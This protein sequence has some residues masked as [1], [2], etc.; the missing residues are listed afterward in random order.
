MNKPADHEQIEASKAP[1]LEHLVELRTRLLYSLAGFIVCFFGCYF[2]AEYIYAFL[3][4]PLANAFG[5]ETGRRMIFTA[6]YETF[7]TY[8]RV[9]FFGAM[10]LSFPIVASQIWMFVAPGLYR[11]EKRA[12]LPY[13]VAT[14]LMFIA[15]GAFVFYLVMPVAISFFLSFEAPG[16]E[17]TLPIQLEAK[18]SEYLDLVMTLIFAFGV[19][20]QLPILLTL[21][22][23]VGIIDAATLRMFRRYAIVGVFA[24]AA[25]L[26]PPD[27]LSQVGLA[28]PML[29][30]YEGSIIIVALMERARARRRPAEDSA[31][32]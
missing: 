26:T 32:S 24:V 14:P 15:G 7:L 4:H 6:L 1:L 11:Q 28:V 2:V 30:L 16:G 12:F 17:G 5:E 10:C 22:G 29:L 13:L 27:V 21:L 19:C 18:V 25:V 20:F 3:V 23:H 8:L 9:A 31:E